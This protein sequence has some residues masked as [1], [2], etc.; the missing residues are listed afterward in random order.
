M[1]NSSLFLNRHQASKT[2]VKMEENLRKIFTSEEKTTTSR[3]KTTIRTFL[4][5]NPNDP[6]AFLSEDPLKKAIIQGDLAR[7]QQLSFVL[8]FGGIQHTL[9]YHLI[10]K[11]EGQEDIAEY[12]SKYL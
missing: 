2:V 5:P 1:N 7:V 8:R 12:I 10:A 4:D 9:R 3:K 6:D 11:Q